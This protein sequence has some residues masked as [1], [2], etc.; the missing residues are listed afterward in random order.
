MNIDYERMLTAARLGDGCARE[1]LFTTL[2]PRVNRM[3]HKSLG[4]SNQYPEGRLPP[5]LSAGDVVQDVFLG[6]LRDLDGLR[7]QTEAALM[8]YLSTLSRNRVI[9]AIRFHEARRRDRRR[10]HGEHDLEACEDPAAGPDEKAIAQEEI[11]IFRR[12]IASLSERNRELLYERIENRV[13]YCQLAEMFGLA[14]D[15]STRKFF[16]RAKQDLCARL[17]SAGCDPR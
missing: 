14:S 17:R 6:V 2:I 13:P 10:D 11:A 7:A 5:T 12:V 15:D 3:V 9:D 16:S 8:S 4:R 1:D